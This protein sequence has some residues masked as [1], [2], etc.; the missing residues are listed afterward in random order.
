[1]IGHVLLLLSQRNRAQ[2][3]H[4]FHLVNTWKKFQGEVTGFGGRSKRSDRPCFI[5]GP[6]ET[7]SIIP[8]LDLIKALFIKQAPPREKAG[9]QNVGN[10][11][12]KIKYL[13]ED[14]QC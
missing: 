13:G 12:D 8:M 9:Q 4:G 7:H 10:S 6:D 11:A 14:T 2:Q 3:S 5:A 1:M